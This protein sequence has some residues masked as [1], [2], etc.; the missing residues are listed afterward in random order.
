MHN[1][2]LMF[3]TLTCLGLAVAFQVPSPG[4]VEEFE[5]TPEAVDQLRSSFAE[6]RIINLP[7]DAY[8]WQT[9][10]VVDNSPASAKLK[11]MFATTP[12]LQS[13][14]AQ[15]QFYEYK[16][17]HW[18]VRSYHA[19]DPAPMIYLQAPLTHN[20]A[21]AIY[22]AYAGNMPADGE[23]LADEIERSI[24]DCCPDVKPN[25]K[26]RPDILKKIPVLRPS[27]PKPVSNN[28]TITLLAVAAGLAIA[29]LLQKRNQE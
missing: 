7:D 20:K 6:E 17:E 15:T 26:E 11:S 21:K 18:W 10:L 24:A 23:A 28:V 5:L 9:V 22:K 29:H 16:P 1:R 8:Q 25:D 27:G 13:L 4:T 12:R 3:L 19:G 14:K 2:I